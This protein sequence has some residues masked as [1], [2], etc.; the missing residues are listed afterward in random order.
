MSA[1]DV[2]WLNDELV[3]QVGAAIP[4]LSPGWLYAVG[5]FE[6]MRWRHPVGIF[7]FASHVQRLCGS[8]RYLGMNLR[9]GD[10]DR[11]AT[12]ISATILANRV[13]RDAVV[14]LTVAKGVDDEASVEMV[15]VREYPYGDGFPNGVDVFLDSSARWTELSRHKTLNYTANLLA[16]QSA[17]ERGCFDALFR[18]PNGYLLEG[19][20]TNVFTVAGDDIRTPSTQ[21]PLLAGV[22]RGVILEI[23]ARQGFAAVESDLT[24]DDLLSASEAFLTNAVAGVVPVTGIVDARSTRIPIGGSAMGARTRAL[25]RAY[26]A[27]CRDQLNA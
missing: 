13:E 14:R 23:A 5:A 1:L 24:L 11:Y 22:T 19:A 9:D 26:E 12:A 27:K 20:A 4:A 6:T 18:D 3:P 8:L 15:H 7:R 17:A 16:R 25:M 10:G 2:V 21:R